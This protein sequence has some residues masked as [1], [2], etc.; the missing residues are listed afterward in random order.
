MAG[1]FLI[2][3][4]KESGEFSV[5]SYLQ[6][7][8]FFLSGVQIQCFTEFVDSTNSVFLL[9]GCLFYLKFTVES[10]N[11]RM[12]L[13]V[14]IDSPTAG[15]CVLQCVAVCCSVLQCVAVCCSE[16][17]C[18]AVITVFA[19]VYRC[20][21]VLQCVA[22]CCNVLQ[23]VVECCGVLQGDT[24][25]VPGRIW[26]LSKVARKQLQTWTKT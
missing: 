3:P 4:A 21:C 20:E 15:V 12:L 17:Q 1:C 22:A 25:V 18:V 24:E 16:L 6:I 13:R 19:S 11:G 26:W 7:Q 2:P 8:C 14:C 23:S 10:G 9:I 5:S